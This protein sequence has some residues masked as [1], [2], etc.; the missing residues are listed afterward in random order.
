[1]FNNPTL[2]AS[3][4]P[5]EAMPHQFTDRPGTYPFHHIVSDY[6]PFTPE[7]QAKLRADLLMHGF[8]PRHPIWIW[9]GQIVEGFHRETEARNLR[10]ERAHYEDLGDISEEADAHHGCPGER[11]PPQQIAHLTVTVRR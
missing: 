11:V 8:D 2:T 5:K 9:R 6:E 3:P 7:E 1:V 10:L 4:K